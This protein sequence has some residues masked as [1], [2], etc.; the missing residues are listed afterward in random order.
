MPFCLHSALYAPK[1]MNIRNLQSVDN[2]QNYLYS[3][4][5]SSLYLHTNTHWFKQSRQQRSPA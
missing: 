2:T 3:C 5:H 1:L 4:L